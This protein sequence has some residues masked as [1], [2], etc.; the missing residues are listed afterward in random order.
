MYKLLL[1]RCWLA[2]ALALL[3]AT[4][5][6][7]QFEGPQLGAGPFLFQ[8]FEQD[9]V[10][11]SVVARGM[12]HPFGLVF[13]PGTA[14]DDNPLG[15]LL[16]SERSGKLRLLRSGALQ[17]AA[18]IDLKQ[19]LPLEQLFDLKLHPQ[20]AD[21]GLI[22]FTYIK[23]APN[24]DGSKDYWVTTALGRGRF[25]GTAFVDVEDVFVA[26]AWS[27]NIGGASSRLHFLPDGTLLFGVSHRIDEEAPQKLDNHIGKI[28]RLNDDGTAPADNPYFATEGA[29]PEIYTWGNRSVMDFTTHPATGAVWE[30]EN[31]PQGGDEVNILKPGANFGWPIA[32]Y[33]RDY[34]GT[35]FSPRPYVEG[36]D[37]PELFWVPSIT[38]AGLTFYSG[39]RFPKW[40]NNLFVTSMIVGRIPGTG[41]LVRIVF[42][43]NGEVRREE[44]FKPL[45][46]RFRYI[47][48]GPDGLLYALTD[49]SDGVLL[50]IEPG[51][52]AEFAAAAAAT[53]ASLAQATAESGGLNA[54]PLFA[55][56]DCATC[57]RMIDTLI[58]PGY[59]AIAARYEAT[60]DNVALLADRIINGSEGVWSETAMTPH[61]ALSRA[62]AVE[63]V[64]AIL[65]V[66]TD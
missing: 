54:T 38:V 11:A 20:F 43:E 7:A 16:I 37:L 40:T 18:V 48:Q 22:Y 17:A 5:A 29:L 3:P 35:R 21:N 42:N 13:L 15:D 23:T 24:P 61:A 44:L 33:G 4:L 14:D 31:G 19:S 63:M 45:Q 47:Q 57:H 50:R 9:Y 65:A 34:D 10:K 51:T 36:T 30:L 6:L 28:L 39:D 1:T 26:E 60:G 49:H 52:A 53:A 46:Q 58:G 27:S 55:G 2:V 62:T 66:D 32:T 8:T 41:H 64:Q 59:S 56:Q 25:T 12:D